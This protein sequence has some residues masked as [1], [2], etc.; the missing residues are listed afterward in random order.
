MDCFIECVSRDFQSLIETL[1]IS[2]SACGRRQIHPLQLHHLKTRCQNHH[3]IC[4]MNSYQRRRAYLPVQHH[5]NESQYTRITRDRGRQ[6]NRGWMPLLCQK[7]TVRTQYAYIVHT[8]TR[9]LLKLSRRPANCSSSTQA[10]E[11]RTSLAKNPR[12]T[13]FEP[14]ILESFHE[15]SRIPSASCASTSSY[16]GGTDSDGLGQ[17]TYV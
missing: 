8:L 3:K 10:I 7:A 2:V 11:S 15:C 12:S 17:A 16:S 1:T 13:E 9:L 4:A 5:A 6:R 14:C